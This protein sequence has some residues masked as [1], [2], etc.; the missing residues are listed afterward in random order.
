MYFGYLLI[1]G[2]LNKALSFPKRH[3]GGLKRDFSDVDSYLAGADVDFIPALGLC[4]GGSGISC[5]S[6][7]SFFALKDY[8]SKNNA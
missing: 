7:I 2:A 4:G 3:F 6:E 8:F 5:K 1:C